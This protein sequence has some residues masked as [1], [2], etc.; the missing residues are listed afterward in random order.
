M[1]ER[2]SRI[3]TKRQLDECH[4]NSNSS[5]IIERSMIQMMMILC[6]IK[7]EYIL[8]VTDSDPVLSEAF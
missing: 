7:H 1:N 5:K 2:E 8:N 4:G 3:V 6:L